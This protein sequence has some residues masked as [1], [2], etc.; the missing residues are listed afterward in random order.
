[1]VVKADFTGFY[2][3]LQDPAELPHHHNS[4]L[5]QKLFQRL[6]VG[7]EGL[8]HASAQ[9]GQSNLDQQ[10]STSKVNLCLVEVALV[11]IVRDTSTHPDDTGS[12]HF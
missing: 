8:N 1:M 6:W 12:W 11:T 2:R 7:A 4:E 9:Q 10:I 5:E 3:I